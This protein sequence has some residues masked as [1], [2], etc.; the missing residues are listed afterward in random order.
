MEQI[1]KTATP[2][3]ENTV[4]PNKSND[5][6]TK[7]TM[8]DIEK[9]HF[10]SDQ[11]DS[12]ME[13][14]NSAVSICYEENV[15][16]VFNFDPEAA[17][18]EGYGIAVIPLTKRVPERGNQTVG[19][20]VAAVPDFATIYNNDAGKS[21][22]I[23]QATDSL[24]KQI[25]TAAKPKDEGALTSLPFKIEDF[26]TSTRVSGLLAFNM[27]ASL[28][29]A[30]LKKK[31]LKFMTKVLLRQVLASAA[32]AEQQFPRIA[33]ENWAIVLN[34]MVA[35]V[36]KEGVDAGVLK[37]WLATRD[38]TEIDTT[39]IDLSDIDGMVDA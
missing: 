22:I 3:T 12:G 20:V 38:E 28:F 30:A 1:N 13:Y 11:I 18:P 14:V 6:D 35:H 7:P 19:I 39:E 9:K 37:H 16:P 23:K 29:V 32:F 21:W 15:E 8:Q 5:N 25:V 26:V 2:T 31:G 17:F 34:S 33:Q 10:A 27:V 4:D 24:V 36:E